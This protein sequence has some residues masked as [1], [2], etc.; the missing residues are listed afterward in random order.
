M[1][2]HQTSAKQDVTQHSVSTLL[3]LALVENPE[4]A[5]EQEHTEENETSKFMLIKT[6]IRSRMRLRTAGPKKKVERHESRL[7]VSWTELEAAK[8]E[9]RS[10]QSEL[11]N[12]EPRLSFFS[13]KLPTSV[14][15]SILGQLGKRAGKRAACV[16]QAWRDVVATAKALGMYKRSKLLSVSA[17]DGTTAICTVD[18]VFTC[19]GGT[20][21]YSYS[22]DHYGYALG[23]GVGTTAKELSPRVI[24]ALSGASVVGVTA[25]CYHTAVS[26]DR[27]RRTLHLWGGIAWGAG[28]RQ[29]DG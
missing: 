20:D 16:K 21:T 12:L 6:E 23:H 13:P 11:K 17:G 8:A 4:Q 10:A 1:S 27:C 14:L 9:V 5:T 29:E 22:G 26:L 25:G 3:K 7:A 19:G 18:G 2:T 28:A 15:L 24:E